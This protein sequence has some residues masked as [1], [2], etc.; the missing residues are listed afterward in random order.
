MDKAIKGDSGGQ[1]PAL[2]RSVSCQPPVSVEEGIAVGHIWEECGAAHSP[3]SVPLPDKQSFLFPWEIT[4]S[5]QIEAVWGTQNPKTV[6]SGP[7]KGA[8]AIAEMPACTQLQGLYY[9]P[10]TSLYS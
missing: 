3:I 5:P 1:G 9:L 8:G 6:C 10:T 7:S 2:T 4:F